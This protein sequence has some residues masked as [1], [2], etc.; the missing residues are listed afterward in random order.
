M[1]GTHTEAPG[2]TWLPCGDSGG[3][4]WASVPVTSQEPLAR[5]AAQRTEWRPQ[6]QKQ[7][8]AGPSV[9]I[10]PSCS[11]SHSGRLRRAAT[12][13]PGPRS[14]PAEPPAFP[15]LLRLN[16]PLIPLHSHD[17]DF[18]PLSPWHR[19][20]CQGRGCG[21]DLLHC[22]ACSPGADKSSGFIVTGSRQWVSIESHVARW[23]EGPPRL[24]ECGLLRATWM[25]AGGRPAQRD[26]QARAP[27]TQE[28][29]H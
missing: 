15:F 12:Q 9:V 7:R 23:P 27:Y 2:Q 5:R 21:Q 29:G 22:W 25:E 24:R 19:E 28:G 3:R 10:G 14:F 26:K 8:L 20:F 18:A 13:D 6:L 4:S 1:G 11:G 17:C 16:L